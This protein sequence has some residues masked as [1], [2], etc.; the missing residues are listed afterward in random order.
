MQGEDCLENSF[1][2]PHIVW[3]LSTLS[4]S[5]YFCAQ[6]SAMFERA[7]CAGKVGRVLLIKGGTRTLE[8]G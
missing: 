6:D 4:T 2:K 8:S 1:P 3:E 5:F 7:L